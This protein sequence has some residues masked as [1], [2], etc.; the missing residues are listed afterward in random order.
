V[1]FSPRA[2]RL[3]AKDESLGLGRRTVQ[4]IGKA[5]DGTGVLKK[6]VSSWLCMPVNCEKLVDHDHE[7]SRSAVSAS[8]WGCPDPRCSY[9]PSLC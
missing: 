2:K 3:K 8:S 1:S 6:T 4:Q 5:P 9:S 7:K